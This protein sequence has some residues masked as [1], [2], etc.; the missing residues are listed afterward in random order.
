MA[1]GKDPVE[2]Y[3][4]ALRAYDAV[5]AK[6]EHMVAAVKDAA[7]KLEKWDQV[8]IPGGAPTPPGVLEMGMV[9]IDW[10][11]LPPGRELAQALQAWH[12]ACQEAQATWKNVPQG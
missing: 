2:A 8:K 4:E 6:I 5:S 12:K 11:R 10:D 3:Q 1:V 7:M 9:S